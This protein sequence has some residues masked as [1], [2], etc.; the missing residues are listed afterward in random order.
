MTYVEVSVYTH[1]IYSYV[2]VCRYAYI[3][4]LTHIHL[5]ARTQHSNLSLIMPD[6]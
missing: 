6:A 5:C 2:Y 4:T 3:P 1:N